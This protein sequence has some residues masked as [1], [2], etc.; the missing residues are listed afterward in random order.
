MKDEFVNYI[1]D[2]SV[3]L[4]DL[5]NKIEH[6]NLE[7]FNDEDREMLRTEFDGFYDKLLSEEN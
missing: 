3:R 6:K 2:K 7:E 5:A 1:V 4:N